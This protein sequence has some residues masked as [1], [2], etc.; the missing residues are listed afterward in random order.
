MNACSLSRQNLFMRRWALDFITLPVSASIDIL[1]GRRCMLRSA[2]D[3]LSGSWGR[4]CDPEP[5]S[6]VGKLACSETRAASAKPTRSQVSFRFLL[7]S[8]P[9][10]PFWIR[11]P[12]LRGE[13]D[14]LSLCFRN[15]PFPR[16][17]RGRNSLRLFQKPAECSPPMALGAGA[18]RF[19]KPRGAWE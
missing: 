16:K 3:N 8:A 18:Q 15:E 2:I 11:A 17:G 9:L 14:I 7:G 4:Q 1:S 13:F 19:A 6:R 12:S 10:L 5:H